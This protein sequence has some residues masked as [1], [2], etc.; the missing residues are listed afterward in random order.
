M[1]QGCREKR[2]TGEWGGRKG[3]ERKKEES[4]EKTGESEKSA[5]VNTSRDPAGYFLSLRADLSPPNDCPTLTRQPSHAS[6]SHFAPS[7][8][9]IAM[10]SLRE[11]AGLFIHHRY[12]S[13]LSLA[14]DSRRCLSS[15]IDLVGWSGNEERT[16]ERVA[17]CWRA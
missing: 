16:T 7:S 5:S 8:H 4:E 11:I 13:P 6:S 15:N 10:P 17:G 2:N 3:E 14:P 1:V 12:I 9:P